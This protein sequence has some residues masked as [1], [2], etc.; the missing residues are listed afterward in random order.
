MRV[1]SVCAAALLALL[2]ASPAGAA[3]KPYCRL[4]VDARGDTALADTPSLDVLSADVVSDARRITAVV[5]VAGSP[6][7]FGPTSPAGHR[8][9]VR[10]SGQGGT[11]AVF[12]WYVLTPTGG[13]AKYGLYDDAGETE[14]NL[15]YATARVAGNAVHLTVPV[16]AL[17]AYGRFTRG[18]R[19]TGLTAFAFRWVGAYATPQVYAHDS[20]EAD[21]AT[22]GKPYVA[23]AR[24]CVK[25]G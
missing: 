1:R 18:A 8:Y 15:G 13:V 16:D 25:P 3:T 14:T 20:R 23:G 22:G 4:L 7:V 12:V 6:S 2:G 17:R 19:I 10:F 21:R 24:S 5:R 9:L 11:L